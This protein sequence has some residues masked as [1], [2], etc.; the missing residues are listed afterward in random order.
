MVSGEV[1]QG[2]VRRQISISEQANR[3]LLSHVK[4]KGDIS[5][6]IEQLILHEDEQA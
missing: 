4:K 2:N 6:H 1:K 3:I 5:S